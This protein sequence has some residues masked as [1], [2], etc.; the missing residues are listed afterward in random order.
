MLI[1]FS[2]E[3]DTDDSSAARAAWP[4]SRVCAHPAYRRRLHLLPM[5]SSVSISA[6][7]WISI[8]KDADYDKTHARIEEMVEAYPGLYRDV[9]TYLK[10]RIRGG[11]DGAAR[12]SSSASSDRI[13]TCCG[14]R[15]GSPHALADIP[16]LVNL[17]KD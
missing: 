5:R 16:D 8:S 15:R 1:Q 3:I 2:P 6:E 13:S 12:R 17:H 7:N 11:P 9:Q 4:K 10:E 14:T